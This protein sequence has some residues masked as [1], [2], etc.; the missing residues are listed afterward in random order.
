[1]STDLSSA[2]KAVLCGRAIANRVLRD[3]PESH[4]IFTASNIG[5]QVSALSF[6]AKYKEYSKASR[7]VYLT[8]IPDHAVIRY[9]RD[10][11]D[12]VQTISS[13][14]L[15]ALRKFYKSDMGCLYLRREKR[16]LYLYLTAFIRN[17]LLMNCKNLNFIQI[18]KTIYRIPLDTEPCGIAESKIDYSLIEKY[19]EYIDPNNTVIINPYS[20][21][22]KGIP[23]AF[24]SA[25]AGRLSAAGMKVICSTIGG[26]ISVENSVPLSFDLIEAVPLFN[27]CGYVVG[28]RSGFLD[29][30]AQTQAVVASVDSPEYLYA[31]YYRLEAWGKGED[32]RSFRWTAERSGELA[33]SVAEFILR[34]KETKERHS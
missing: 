25:V 15:Q 3:N 5:D 14:D 9:Y 8:D 28:F 20:N 30:A 24:F 18:L 17:V 23:L 26:Q 1:M 10:Q 16:L 31:D 11:F 34:A 19:Q 27:R 12:A 29:L 7:I 32:I 22:A 21:S 4:V 2:I 6:I 13:S 33:D